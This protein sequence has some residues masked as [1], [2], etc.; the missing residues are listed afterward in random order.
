MSEINLGYEPA[1]IFDTLQ[2]KTLEFAHSYMKTVSDH[3][4]VDVAT[5]HTEDE[6]ESL[7]LQ[8]KIAAY[9]ET[10]DFKEEW[11]ANQLLCL[12][13]LAA[14]VKESLD[15]VVENMPRE[16]QENEDTSNT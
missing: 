1:V 3:V 2:R 13:E 16:E 4:G 7:A 8:E 11:V 10:Q 6:E 12:L 15:T 5:Y 9:I 14:V